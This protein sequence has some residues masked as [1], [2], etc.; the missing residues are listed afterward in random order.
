L[1]TALGTAAAMVAL[2]FALSTYERWLDGRR[3]QELAWTVSLAMF[4]LASACLAAGAT[5][6]WHGPV[7]RLF[8]F[9]G[10]VANVPFLALGTIYLL[11]SRRTGDRTAIAISLAVAFAGGV[12]AVAP[13]QA[14]LSV[15]QL[16]Q[17]SDVFDPFP[18]VLAALAS[19]GGALVVFAGAVWSAIRYR[20]GRMVAANAFIAIGTAVT[21]ASGLLNSVFDEMTG[22]A[23]FLLAGIVLIFA[24]FLVA[25]STTTRSG[26][27]SASDSDA[28]SRRERRGGGDGA[29][30][31]LDG[32]PSRPDPVAA[33]PR[34]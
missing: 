33:T 8:W 31:E 20:R 10:A 9:F 13:F 19:G 34:T 12:I 3:P 28:L 24:G 5:G 11:A 26:S 25:S 7:F 23:V 16:P 22:F 17:G 21:G 27:N 32:A 1:H 14:P 29:S 2:A 6:G 15:D 4:S 30:E 18:R